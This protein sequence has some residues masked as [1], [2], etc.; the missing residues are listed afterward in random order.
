MKSAMQKGFTLIELMIVVAI[1]GILA[2]VA[3]PAYQDYTLKARIA[4]AVTV[5][6]TARNAIGMACSDGSLASGMTQ[7]SLNLPAAASFATTNTVSSVAAAGTSA[8]AGT[9][10]I[11]LKAIGSIG[12]GDTIVYTATCGTNGMTWAI[13]GTGTLAPGGTMVRLLPKS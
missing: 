4:E 8:T 3:L 13:S 11:T 1:V 9:V 6:E 5:S 2:A 12:S 10:T 7:A